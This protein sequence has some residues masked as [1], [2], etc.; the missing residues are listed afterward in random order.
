MLKDF[1]KA[2]HDQHD[3]QIPVNYDALLCL[4]GIDDRAATLYLNYSEERSEVTLLLVCENFPSRSGYWPT[5]LSCNSICQWTTTLWLGPGVWM[6]PSKLDWLCW[7]PGLFAAFPPVCYD[8]VYTTPDP[9]GQIIWDHQL[10]LNDIIL[11]ANY[12]CPDLIWLIQHVY[13]VYH[14][15]QG[16]PDID[17]VLLEK[18][19]KC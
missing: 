5:Y 1:A 16:H 11:A 7:Y 9:L 14:S 4:L 15:F 12:V 13:R 6:D 2:L 17:E 3:G 8:E 19:L 18:P 10:P